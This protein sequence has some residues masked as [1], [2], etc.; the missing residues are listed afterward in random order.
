MSEEQRLRVVVPL[1]QEQMMTTKFL[2]DNA[3]QCSCGKMM[4][5]RDPKFVIGQINTDYFPVNEARNTV[6]ICVYCKDCF[7]IINNLFQS[8]KN[9]YL[10]KGN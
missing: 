6:V 1:S 2:M 8:I 10:R 9:S 7:Y 3:G 4:K 5:A